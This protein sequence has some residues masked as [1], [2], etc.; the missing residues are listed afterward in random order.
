MSLAT[1]NAIPTSKP[2]RL[3]VKNIVIA[4]GLLGLWL[5]VAGVIAL[6]IGKYVFNYNIKELQTFML[7]ILVYS[8]RFRVLVIREK[9]IL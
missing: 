1:D 2:G 5:L 6:Y 9:S 8:S 7:L 3:N 4:S